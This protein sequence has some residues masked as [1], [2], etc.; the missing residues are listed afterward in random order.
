MTL[1]TSAAARSVT[2]HSQTQLMSTTMPAS[3]P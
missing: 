1:F 3:D 2:A